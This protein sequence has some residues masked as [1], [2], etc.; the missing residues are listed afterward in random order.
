M[1][2]HC[3][4]ASH[5]NPPYT[6][7]QKGTFV[8]KKQ[9]GNV[10]KAYYSRSHELSLQHFFRVLPV[11]CLVCSVLRLTQIIDML[12]L[13]VTL[14]GSNHLLRYSDCQ[15]KEADK[16][17]LMITQHFRQLSIESDFF[18]PIFVQI[19]CNHQ[20][21]TYV[22]SANRIGEASNPGPHQEKYSI[23]LI[24][25]TTVLHREPALTA[26][27]VDLIAMA[28]TSATKL[29]QTQVRKNMR[30]QGYTTIWSTPVD[31]HR[32]MLNGQ[33]SYRGVAAGVAFAARI[34]MR[35]YRD[36]QPKDILASSRLQF[37][38]V[39]FGATPVLI[40]VFYG[41]ASGNEMAQQ[42]T[43]R[44]LEYAV[45]VM[46]SH[47]GPSMLV[48]DFNHDLHNLPAADKLFQAGFMSTKH[49][50]PTLYG[51]PMPCTYQEA[52][53]RDLMIFSTE[54]A[55]AIVKIEVVK[56]A[57][58][59]NH[60]PVIAQLSLPKGGLSKK[61]W[62]IPK[63]WTELRPNLE[64]HSYAYDQLDT[65]DLTE[66]FETNLQAWSDK[67]EV[68]LDMSIKLQHRINPEQQP[69]DALPKN[70][71]GK[72][73]SIQ[74][75]EQRF[76]A[77]TPTARVG[78]FEPSGEVRSI[79]H[80]QIIRQLRRIQSLR[81]RVQKLS[82]YETIWPSTWDGL[83]AEWTAIIKG[84]GFGQHFSHWVCNTLQWPFITMTLPN[85]DILQALEEAVSN[86]QQLI[87]KHEQQQKLA[88]AY[89]NHQIDHMYNYDRQAYASIREPPSQFIQMLTTQWDVEAVVAQLETDTIQ[90]QVIA[91]DVPRIGAICD[92]G[93][94]KTV[95]PT[96]DEQTFQVANTQLMK[97]MQFSIGQRLPVHIES[98]GMQPQDIHQALQN[99][100]NPIW[101]RDTPE[102]SQSETKWQEVS[103][104]LM[105]IDMPNIMQDIDLT[106]FAVWQQ[107][108]NHTNSSSAP[109]ADGWYYEELKAIPKQALKELI[110]VFN[111]HSF[112]GFPS[113]L[114]KARVVPLPKKDETEAAQHT[115]PIT[116]LPTLYRLWSA[117]V[118]HQIMQKAAQVLPTGM[119]GF[120][121][122][123]SGHTGMYQLAWQLEEAHYSGYPLSGLTL[124]LTK[125]F[126][127]FPR[128]PVLM[129]LQAMGIPIHLLQQW[130]FS[131]NQMEKFFD[132]RGWISDFHKST[133][134]I[135]EGDG[136]S[137]VCMIGVA[138]FWMKMIEHPAINPMAYADNLSWSSQDPQA[139]ERALARTIQCFRVLRIPIDWQKT[140]VWGTHKSHRAHWKTIATQILP[141]EQDLQILHSSVDLG[142]VMNYSANR[143]LL[144][145]VDRLQAAITRLQRLFRQNLAVDVIAKVI[146]TAVWP[147]A[148]YGQE[149]SLLGRPHF[150]DIRVA[151]AKAL[152]GKHQPGLAAIANMIASNTLA[153]PELY[154][155]ISA[156]RTAKQMLHQMTSQ[157][158]NQF[159][160]VASQSKGTC[161]SSKGPA[162]ALKGYLER[163]G[164]VFSPNGLLRLV[165]GINLHLCD[166]PFPT[167]ANFLKEEWMRD[168][169]IMTSERKTIIHAP[170][171]SRKHT[172]QVLK[173]FSISDQ[174]RLLQEICASFQMQDQKAHWTGQDTDQCP[175]CVERD[176]RRHRATAC[177]A[178]QDIYDSHTE[179]IQQLQEY[180]DIHFDL[181]VIYH[182]PY[183]DLFQQCNFAEVPVDFTEASIR[184]VE[185]QIQ[186][187]IRPT[188]FT[189]GSCF[190]PSMA[191]LAMSAWAIVLSTVVDDLD[192]Q[193]VVNLGT[194]VDN[195]SSS[196]ISV[197]ISRSHG[198]Q[199]TDRAELQAA[200]SL[201]ERWN[202]TRLVTD[203]DY[204][205]KTVDMV[206]Q[207]QDSTTLAM[208]PN[209]DLLLRLYEALP[210]S[211]HHLVKVESHILEGRT[212]KLNNDPFYILGNYVADL[213]AKRANH[214]LASDMIR[215]WEQEHD[216]VKQDQTRLRAYYKLLLDIQPQRAKMEHNR[217][218][219][220]AQQMTMP[221]SYHAYKTLPQ[222]LVEWAPE[223]TRQFNLHWP[224]NISLKSPWGEEIMSAA[225]QWWNQL[226]WPS[227]ETGVIQAAGITW[228]ELLLDFLLDRR[229]NIPVRNPCSTSKTME[230]SLYALK[231]AGVAFFHVVKN[232][233]W[234][235]MWLNKRLNG[236]MLEGLQTVRVT[237]LQRQGSTNRHH[238]IR[239]RPV[240]TN[241][242]TVVNTVGTFR[243]AGNQRFSGMVMWPWDDHFFLTLDYGE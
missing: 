233:Y 71:K 152:L 36:E 61:I 180:N 62:P 70:Y 103:D 206:K 95:V 100:W 133:T 74:P 176:T 8:I 84:K 104:I 149:T 97:D 19:P 226:R 29:T 102:E 125:A 85:F 198:E 204:V 15:V 161:A 214:Q 56:G 105:N 241:Q 81:R 46:L 175:F 182:S 166:T 227:A 154:V 138:M 51:E 159:Y 53:T 3:K 135:V 98:R 232:F 66:D 49:L 234:M 79:R 12:Q 13:L 187:G 150:Q 142:M 160:K 216:Q 228:G 230:R 69:N 9:G 131:P 58:F 137:I 41:L 185:R 174:R 35:P 215:Q 122:G 20:D 113:T 28:E 220:R 194:Q 101:N 207:V 112:H 186:R 189:D 231:H 123:R 165:S 167:I 201:M 110:Q 168:L 18:P 26:L 236:A 80:T 143:R 162:S 94:S 57:E 177:P 114:M 99:Y 153:D 144:K 115:R 91:G 217:K 88:T 191:T 16:K 239:A 158:R 202:Y 40:G 6:P 213:T 10:T 132:H 136:L 117:V 60:A 127:Q 22:V 59:P 73:Q 205:C 188:F 146:A 75:K 171:I 50:Y 21:T 5:Q 156:V 68:S 129:I 184:E 48:G 196:F 39:Q 240:L 72:L 242:E 126:N 128:I 218:T 47:P 87:Q 4:F 229:L 67:V 210:N 33:E 197:A 172:Q 108:I 43:N 1:W 89:I 106:S 147:K 27:N 86:H 31:N 208:K 164:I 65:L 96:F 130:I 55:A 124:D 63:N 140:W 25:P 181:P 42:E 83:Q 243:E 221:D 107:V 120:V 23:G 64:L 179:V 116:V 192:K 7:I 44:L 82:T 78:D 225:M 148:F 157:Q 139:H 238:G 219:A 111:H 169:P 34:P 170:L 151:A 24:N 14:F 141:A 121:K 211:D 37:A 38:H 193:R 235:M 54:L 203:S 76:R 52:T 30:T 77:F 118:A 173:Q 17:H 190:A 2:S 199:S 134:G 195:L 90:F 45:E 223:H 178:L 200:T 222:Q 145:I 212:P 237:S 11:V 224:D 119:I 209:A 93:Q 109:G 163:L 183:N 155:I 92:F 32:D